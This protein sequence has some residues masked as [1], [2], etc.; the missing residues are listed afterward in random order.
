MS[1][2]VSLG[3]DDRPRDPRLQGPANQRE[4]A[5]FVDSDSQRQA[6]IRKDGTFVNAAV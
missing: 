1:A 6:Y 4:V 5:F 2:D 3:D